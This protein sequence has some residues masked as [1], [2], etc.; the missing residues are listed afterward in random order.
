MNQH[1]CCA[2]PSPSY[3]GPAECLVR[4]VAG[5]RLGG[6]SDIALPLYMFM[7]V[8]VSITMPVY[9]STPIHPYNNAPLTVALLYSF[10]CLGQTN[11]QGVLTEAMD[12]MGRHGVPLEHLLHLLEELPTECHRYIHVNVGGC[13]FTFPPVPSHA[14]TNTCPVAHPRP[15]LSIRENPKA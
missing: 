8:Y 7:R 10:L 11:W 14:R 9:T 1:T 3:C 6:G 15:P 13:M 5:R 2:F 4:S 12:L